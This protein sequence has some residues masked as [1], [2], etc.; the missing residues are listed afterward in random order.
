MGNRD[1]P[2]FHRVLKMD[3]A[4]FLGDLLPSVSPQSRKNVSTVQC[5][6]SDNNSTH[7]YT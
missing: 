7:E 1:A 5:R 6:P 3:V 2:N 4:S